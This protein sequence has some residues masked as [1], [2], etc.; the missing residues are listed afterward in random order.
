MTQVLA[1]TP[2]V[3]EQIDRALAATGRI[4]DGV[5]DG[6]WSAPTPCPDWDAR[7]LTNHLV[8]GLRM[9]A[10]AVAGGDGAAGFDVD[11]LGDD[12]KAAYRDAAPGASAA[13]HADGALDGVVRISLGPIPGRLAAVVHLTEIVVHGVDLAVA[14]GQEHAVDEDLCAELLATMHDMGGID[15]FRVPDVFGPEVAPPQDAPAS[16]RLLA[17]VGRTL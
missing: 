14:T 9:F 8:G 17:Y 3:V 11:W 15:A 6:G 12:P 16:R 4:V 7:A 13:W 10:T 1:P 2:L 5:P